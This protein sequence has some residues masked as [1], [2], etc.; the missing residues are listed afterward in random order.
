M[1]TDVSPPGEH[2]AAE[3]AAQHM[4]ER[5][6]TYLASALVLA[7]M[8]ITLLDV[9][10]RDILNQ[11]LRG[12]TELTELL[13]VGMTFLFYPRIAWRGTHITVDLFDWFRSDLLR[14]IQRVVCSL[15]GALAFGGLAWQL[16]F[17]G[18]RAEGYGDITPSLGLHLSWV[19]WFMALMS[20]ITALAFVLRMFIAAPTPNPDPL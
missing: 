17:N 7:L 2:S 10:G 3:G 9:L 12:A 16:A 18:V 13:L 4:L 8:A 14:T 15:L 5:L 6:S 20:A 11:P 19:L 1:R